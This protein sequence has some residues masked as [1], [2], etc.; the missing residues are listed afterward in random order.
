MES[1]SQNTGRDEVREQLVQAARQVFVRF[2]YKKTALDDIAR[3]ARKGKSTIYYYFKSKDDIF[4]AVIDAEAEIRAKTIDDQISTIDDPQ[5]KLKTYI[6]VRML[7]LKKVG[8]YY[9]AIKNDLLDN[10]YFVNSLRTNH[11]DAEVNLVKEL[12]LEGIEKEVYTI[13]NP[14]LTARTIVT[15]LQGF[16]VP[17]ILKN[18]SDEDL[19]KSVDEMLNILFFGIVTKK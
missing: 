5:Q 15:L 19:Q 9:E 14:E 8:N 18:L 6:Y 11:F 17:L 3:E 12:L 4:K 7:T 16:E 1:S 2:G 10:L 13:Q